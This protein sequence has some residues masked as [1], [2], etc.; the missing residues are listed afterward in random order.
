MP[1]LTLTTDIGQQDFLVGAIKGRT[2]AKRFGICRRLTGNC[3]EGARGLSIL[4]SARN[5]FPKVA[6]YRRTLRC[7]HA[8][9]IT[10][11]GN[12]RFARLTFASTV[13]YRIG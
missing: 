3:V 2:A 10:C 1:L 11:P 9:R 4:C 8:L 12:S 13:S 5:I 7:D 6:R